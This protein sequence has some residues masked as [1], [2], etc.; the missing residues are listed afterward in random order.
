MRAAT[1]AAE[2]YTFWDYQGGA[3]QKNNGIR[4]DHVL[5]SPEAAGS[6]TSVA[7]EK[8][9]RTWEKPSDHVPVVVRMD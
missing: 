4:I 1:D 3:W 5:L 7:I 2:T 6:L 9:V 8:H